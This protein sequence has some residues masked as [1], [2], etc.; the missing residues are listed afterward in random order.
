MT[1]K[2]SG[3]LFQKIALGLLLVFGLL[4]VS[5]FPVDAVMRDSVSEE[6]GGG[7]GGGAGGGGTTT[8]QCNDG[9]DNDSNTKTDYPA[10]LGCTSA[11]DPTESG[12][13]PAPQCS[14]GVDNDSNGLIDTNDQGCSSATDTSESGFVTQCGDNIDNDNNGKKD[15][16]ADLG[17]SAKGDLTEAGYTPPPTPPPGVQVYKTQSKRDFLGR[18]YKDQWA[19]GGVNEKTAA[20]GYPQVPVTTASPTGNRICSLY[21]PTSFITQ[22][23]LGGFDSPGGDSMA[24]WRPTTGKWYVQSANSFGNRRYNY[25]TCVTNATP[26][27]SLTAT[28]NG[29]TGTNITV[30]EGTPVT[31]T[32]KSDWGSIRKG[33]M[34][35]I[36]FDLVATIPGHWEVVTNFNCGTGG[37][38]DGINDSYNIVEADRTNL[39]AIAQCWSE[40]PVWIEAS[41]APRPFGGS[42]EVTPTETTT[43]TY[44]GT[45]ANGSS[46]SSVTVTVVPADENGTATLTAEPATITSGSSTLTYTCP[47]GTPSASI[48]QGVGSLSPATGGTKSV[49]PTVTTTYTLT[50]DAPSGGSAS[51]AQAMVTV[52]PV[53]NECVDGQDNDDDGDTDAADLGCPDDGSDGTES[54]SPTLSCNVDDSSVTTTDSVTYTAGVSPSGSY[55]YDWNPLDGQTCTGTGASRNCTFPGTG[56]YRMSLTTSGDADL[57]CNFTTVAVGEACVPSSVTIEASADRVKKG[58]TVDVTWSASEG[59]T[60]TISSS[61]GLHSSTERIGTFED[62]VINGQVKFEASC[63]GTTRSFT[64]NPVGLFN[65]F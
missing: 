22:W 31:L 13:T 18:V 7:G 57:S 38:D 56:N 36:N 8:T 50:C 6:G 23:S 58:D 39:T 24:A 65:E 27:T 25:I 48:N 17:C 55:T 51:T 32:W 34:S 45:N 29:T 19:N 46:S 43:Y 44:K 53:T 61:D 64:V 4:A 10:D 37:G 5:S 14:D 52:G 28:A 60:C 2:L 62:V 47:T 63:S 33:T 12:Y 9:V 42:R 49:S 59:C 3:T 26:D 30:E 41:T 21:D 1:S 35:A 20:H 54:S 40:D 15:Y 11:T 16:P